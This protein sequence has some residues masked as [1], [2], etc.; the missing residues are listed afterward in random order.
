[1]HVHLEI[2]WGVI[3]YCH[4]LSF[5]PPEVIRFIVYAN[6]T[7][8][9]STHHFLIPIVDSDDL[10]ITLAD[11]NIL[12]TYI[13]FVDVTEECSVLDNLFDCRYLS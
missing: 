10:E 8:D 12:V 2:A 7:F 4:T 1:M 11:L 6:E 5:E 3:V 13:S 9:V